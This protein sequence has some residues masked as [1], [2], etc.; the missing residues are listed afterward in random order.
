MTE[1]RWFPALLAVVLALACLAI[2]APTLDRIALN[3]DESQYEATA[4]YLLS[5]GQSGFALPHAS[6][7]TFTLYKGIAWLFG[8]YSMQQVRL[9]VLLVVIGLTGLLFR[10]VRREAGLLAGF[11]AAALFVVGNLPFEGHSANREWFALPGLWGGMALAIAALRRGPR[12]PAWLW[13]LAGAVTGTALW[14]KLQAAYPVL[15]VPLFL[16]IWSLSTRTIRDGLRSIALFAVGGAVSSALYLMAF[17][18]VGTLNSYVAS[19]ATDFSGYAAPADGSPQTTDLLATW[20]ERFLVGLPGTPLVAA[21]YGL[22]VSWLFVI[23]IRRGKTT[24]FPLLMTVHL[25]VCMAAVAMGGRFFGHYYLFLVPVWAV[26]VGIG[27]GGLRDSVS[28]DQAARRIWPTVVAAIIAF[29]FLDLS[30][31]PTAIYLP[32]AVF[33]GYVAWRQ[34][35]F[36][37]PVGVGLLILE[38]CLF[39]YQ[40][41]QTPTPDSLPYHRGGFE[42]VRQVVEKHSDVD[43]P[44]L[45][46][47]WLPEIYSLTRRT[48]ATS[49]VISQYLVQDVHDTVHTPEMDTRYESQMMGELSRTPPVLIVD[50]SA[51]SWTMVAGGSPTLYDLSHYPESEFRRWVAEEYE[52]LGYWDGVAVY[53]R[54]DESSK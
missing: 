47:G 35:A 18:R 51:M 40:A 7:G 53:R 50:A 43:Q 24:P 3:P 13:I 52:P 30:G 39:A 46:W 45:V 36:W 42:N 17:L 29:R 49:F 31:D 41:L 20:W 4:A 33:I 2:R 9:L 21:I 54:R 1:A 28:G 5:T 48:P 26:W 37:R 22:V 8:S 25:G 10:I 44:I 38:S 15:T 12:S 19:I 6:A 27:I 14:F 32:A 11:I 23:V 34:R 16:L